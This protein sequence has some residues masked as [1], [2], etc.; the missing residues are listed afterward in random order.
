MT[1]SRDPTQ[2][3]YSRAAGSRKRIKAPSTHT[4]SQLLGVEMGTI[5]PG[6]GGA[7]QVEEQIAVG[8]NCHGTLS[9]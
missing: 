9:E 7:G 1:F 8:I 6:S 3:Q 4:H 5:F 2:C